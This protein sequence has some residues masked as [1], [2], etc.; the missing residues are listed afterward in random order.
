MTD[1]GWSFSSALKT[2]F[3]V[4]SL[5]EFK[6]CKTKRTTSSV[7]HFQILGSWSFWSQTC[8]RRSLLKKFC[9]GSSYLV[10]L[11][12]HLCVQQ[13]STWGMLH[14]G[15][16]SMLAWQD[17]KSFRWVKSFSKAFSSKLTVKMGRINEALYPIIY[18]LL[19]HRFLFKVG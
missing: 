14:Q 3:C 18:G 8:F 13:S 11:L 1:D 4:C 17:Q 7:T 2:R 12:W 16:G 6:K 5:A 9:F 15:L 10:E 19:E